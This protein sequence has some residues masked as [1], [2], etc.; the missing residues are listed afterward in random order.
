MNSQGNPT[1]QPHSPSL[2]LETVKGLLSVALVAVLAATLF[3]AWPAT[4]A[5][6]DQST[7]NQAGG[8]DS[9]ADQPEEAADYHI[10]LVVGHWGHDVGAICPDSLGG[11]REVDINYTISDLTRQYLQAEGI[12]VDLL[13]EFDDQLENYQ[14]NALISIHADTCEYIPEF[15]TGFKIAETVENKRPE[16]AARLLAC[17][18]NR[19]AAA[20]GLRKDTRLTED[21]T[22]YHAFREISGDTPAV[23]IETGFMN[24]DREL[25]TKHPELPAR[26]ITEGILCYLNR[27]EISPNP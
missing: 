10:G 9:A 7:V 25:L 17:L 22:L 20:T 18:E 26:G 8:A 2:F 23:I 13:K 21:M 15:G 4:G 3:T 24:Q 5:G 14:A 1:H 11:H 12:Q 19:Y 6:A 16:Q 27:E